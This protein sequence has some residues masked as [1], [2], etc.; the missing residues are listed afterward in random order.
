MTQLEYSTSALEAACASL[1][2]QFPG[3][4]VEGIASTYERALPVA[5]RTSPLIL[6]FLGSSVGN[7]DPV[8]MS[9]FLDLVAGHLHP[10]DFLLLGIDL[11]KDR[12]RLEA[13]YNDGAGY[14]EQFTLNLFARMNH[15]LGTRIPLDAIEHVA[16]YNSGLERIEIYAHFRRQ[17]T[18][19]IPLIDRVF[20]LDPGEKV[21]TEISR[22]FRTADMV[23]LP[24]D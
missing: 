8:E 15:E 22:K 6:V 24:G 19:E 14:S 7:F 21:L 13:A 18:I 16:T 17:V 11:V 1:V 20:R 10:D 23:P 2:Q 3:L 4:T 9:A 12:R 5:A